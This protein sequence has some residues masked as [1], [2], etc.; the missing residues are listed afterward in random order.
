MRTLVKPAP[1]EQRPRLLLVRHGER[2]RRAGFGWRHMPALDQEAEA[3]RDPRVVLGRAPDR[4]CEPPTGAQHAAS[5]GERRG[6]VGHQHVP[7]PA[8]HSV[9]R[10]GVELDALGVHHPVLHVLDLE[11][12]AAAAGHIDHRRGEVGR[13]QPAPLAGDRSR[14]EA[15]VASSGRKLEHRVA[16]P[17]RELLEH[18]LPHRGDGLLDARSPALPTRGDRLSDL[19]DRAA[20]VG[21][22]RVESHTRDAT[23]RSASP[24]RAKHPN[25]AAIP[26]WVI[27]CRRA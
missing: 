14:F 9:D 7:E 4:K 2:A 26:T 15:G 13:D 6:G 23:E 18:P 8:E 3:D 10:V 27:L 19:V 11:L 1:L 20:V 25:R 17:R 24:L 22:S 5:L 21:R 16:G 12:G